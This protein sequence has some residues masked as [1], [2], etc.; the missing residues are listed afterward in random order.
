MPANDSTVWGIHAGQTGDADTLFLKQGVVAIGWHEVGDHSALPA[1]RDA[2]K[3]RVGAT[4]PGK[5]PGAI[6][7]DAGQL[8]RF[9]HEMKPGDVVAYPSKRDR[10]I[11]IG[12]VTGP[13]IYNT[14]LSPGYPN[15]RSVNWCTAVPR[16]SF[17]Q[18]ALSEI[19]S[20]MTL[21]QIKKYAAEFLQARERGRMRELGPDGPP[22][23][24]QGPRTIRAHS[25]DGHF[26]VP[27]DMCRAIGV[28]SGDTIL[29]SLTGPHGS[30]QNR[31]VTLRSGTEV[32]GPE[33]QDI[34]KSNDEI[35]ITQYIRLVYRR[36]V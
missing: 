2:F 33:L 29:L 5:K 31:A 6:P 24:Q 8:Y 26:T 11:H 13:Y 4:Y 28:D 17:T 36:N 9:V 32:Y 12:V 35:T 15:Q 19:G 3:A 27:K 20:A 7:V 16:T 14:K 18:G 25:R 30:F 23:G 21:F 1:T 22:Y 34:I 10:H